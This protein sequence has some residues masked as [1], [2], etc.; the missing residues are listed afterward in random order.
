MYHEQL[1]WRFPFLRPLGV[2]LLLASMIF[3]LRRITSSL[4]ANDTNWAAS[5]IRDDE[6]IRLASA[7]TKIFE[8]RQ[9]YGSPILRYTSVRE[10]AVTNDVLP[11]PTGITFAILASNR[12]THEIDAYEP[13]YL[14]ESVANLVEA[15][16]ADVADYGRRYRFINITL[17]PTTDRLSDFAELRD[18]SKLLHPQSVKTR[19]RPL[20]SLPLWCRTLKDA[21]SCLLQSTAVASGHVVLLED[22][23]IVSDRQLLRRLWKLLHQLSRVSANSPPGVVQLHLP[24]GDIT[25][26]LDQASS[27]FELLLISCFL[28]LGLYVCCL[29]TWIRPFRLAYNCCFMLSTIVVCAVLAQAVGRTFWWSFLYHFSSQS[30]STSPLPT[31]PSLGAAVLIPNDLSRELGESLFNRT[32]CLYEQS[33]L[34]DASQPLM[35]PVT[36]AEYIYRFLLEHKQSVWATFPSLFRHRGLYS[37]YKNDIIDPRL[38]E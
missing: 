36:K 19:L 14:T 17:C 26:H 37:F 18:I 13:G 38:V 12:R 1:L 6:E 35:A 5:D 27:V 24:D 31:A 30:L 20:D 32:R 15:I 25:Y 23:I 11:K 28:T 10:G 7:Q 34:V 22:D 4:R 21:G 9:I 3:I 8:W 16:Y 2:I 29:R 33:G